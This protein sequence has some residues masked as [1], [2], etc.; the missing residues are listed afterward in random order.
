MLITSQ[1]LSIELSEK[2]ERKSK[3]EIDVMTD[4]NICSQYIGSMFDDSAG[5]DE[6]KVEIKFHLEWIWQYIKGKFYDLRYA[7]RNRYIW[8]R[9][10]NEIRPWEGFDGLLNVMQTHLK[11]YLNT[12]EKYGHSLEEYKKQKISTV[13][14][15]LEILERMKDPHEYYHKRRDA[16]D[17]KYP[18]YKSLITKYKYGGTSI[19]GDFVRQGGGWVGVEAGKDPRRGYFEFIDDRF[20]TIKS[21]DQYETDRLLA[22]LDK[23]Y[24]EVDDAYKQAELDSDNDFNR[25]SHL[26]KENLYSWWD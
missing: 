16:V 9:T 7:I 20:E 4:Q 19:S 5:K 1:P 23:Y 22:E 26:L 17:L 6:Q 13:I 25:L 3:P 24:I 18:D 11:D 2:Y 10:L 14:E 12:E 21:P 8:R 15:T